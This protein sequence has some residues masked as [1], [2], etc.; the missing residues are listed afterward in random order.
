MATTAAPTPLT[1]PGPRD[2]LRQDDRR[3]E[4]R[5]PTRPEPGSVVLAID[6]GQSALAARLLRCRDALVLVEAPPPLAAVAGPG[7]TGLAATPLLVREE[8]ARAE[9][10][11]ERALLAAEAAGFAVSAAERLPGAARRRRLERLGA[12]SGVGCVAVTT[13]SPRDARGYGRATGWPVLV[14]PPGAETPAGPVVVPAEDALHVAA[15][16]ARVLTSPVAVAVA[17]HD[18]VP[19]ATLVRTAGHPVAVPALLRLAARRRREERDE[20]WDAAETAADELDWAGLRAAPAVRPVADAALDVTREREG[21]LV[22]HD[23]GGLR[24]PRLLGPALRE[25]RP[26]LLVP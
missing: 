16:A 20:A 4:G 23:R 13:R 25:R 10:E 26:V 14:L 11:L 1:S 12:Q 5:P 2:L 8:A 9:E 6:P 18:R 22:L 24:A 21:L 15:A 7:L 3:Q 17:A 19:D